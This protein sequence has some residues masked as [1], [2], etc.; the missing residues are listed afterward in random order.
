MLP[1]NL[2]LLWRGVLRRVRTS[3]EAATTVASSPVARI[4]NPIS[5]IDWPGIRTKDDTTS[6]PSRTPSASKA[7]S[8]AAR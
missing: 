8:R 2:L 4:S 1:M 7:R 5:S 3:V 6:M